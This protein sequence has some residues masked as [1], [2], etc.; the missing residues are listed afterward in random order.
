MG[1]ITKTLLNIKLENLKAKTGRNYYQLEY[2]NG[3]VSLVKRGE[4][5]GIDFGRFFVYSLITIFYQIARAIFQLFPSC[6][7][8]D[9]IFA[10]KFVQYDNKKFLKRC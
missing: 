1:I 3:A 8:I 5:G 7:G 9:R 10:A 6:R 2:A 4:F